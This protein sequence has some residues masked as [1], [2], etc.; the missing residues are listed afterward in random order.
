MK[1]L[2]IIIVLALLGAAAAYGYL[3]W[4]SSRTPMPS[5]MQPAA[6]DEHDGHAH[7]EGDGHDHAAPPDGDGHNHGATPAASTLSSELCAKHRVP[8]RMD[9]FCHPELIESMGFCKGH[10]VPEAFCTRCSPALIAAFK[11]END[12]CA[13]HELPESQ[14]AICNPNTTPGS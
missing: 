11:V 10:D 8:E 2:A 1:N 13:E 14:C 7:A 12:W 9:A 4:R 3:Q 5:A 6:Q